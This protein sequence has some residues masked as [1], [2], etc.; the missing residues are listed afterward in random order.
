[1]NNFKSTWR[2][3]KYSKEQLSEDLLSYCGNDLSLYSQT[4]SH[5]QIYNSASKSQKW[6]HIY[7]HCDKLLEVSIDSIFIEIKL[8]INTTTY[9]KPN[10]N[11]NEL[12][13]MPISFT[14]DSQPI[15]QTNSQCDLSTTTKII[16]LEK[17]A[18]KNTYLY[19]T[20]KDTHIAIKQS[21]LPKIQLTFFNIQNA[22][23]F[24]SFIN[25]NIGINTYSC[26]MQQKINQFKQI[27]GSR[28]IKIISTKKT[29]KELMCEFKKIVIN[30]L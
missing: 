4:I 7:S 16:L 22:L 9:K 24:Y 21:N 15:S 6:L 5:S 8:F 18:I 13:S 1:M 27:V 26:E 3:F 19:V 14:V 20:S 10:N 2:I 30:K 29:I 28:D 23:S 25:S 11:C 12:F 17:I